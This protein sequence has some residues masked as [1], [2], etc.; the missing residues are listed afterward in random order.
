MLGTKVSS[1]TLP[2]NEMISGFN[3]LANLCI[4]HVDHALLD[5]N[6]LVTVASRRLVL[7]VSCHLWMHT[8]LYMSTMMVSDRHVLIEGCIFT[9]LVMQIIRNELDW[10]Q[11]VLNIYTRGTAKELYPEKILRPLTCWTSWRNV[12]KDLLI[13]NISQ[14]MKIVFRE[15]ASHYFNTK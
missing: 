12:I 5:T 4:L 8:P 3:V 15:P 13:N 10:R 14:V 2:C 7:L 6:L 9:W 11:N 1:R